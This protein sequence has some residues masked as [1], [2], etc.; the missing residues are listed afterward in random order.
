MKRWIGLGSLAIVAYLV[1]LVA[2]FPAADAYQW[3]VPHNRVQAY[4]LSG[5]L[6]HGHADALI[7]G[8]QRLDDVRWDFRPDALLSAKLGFSARATLPDGH[9]STR[10]RISP[11]GRITLRDLKV[12]TAL[13]PVVRGL[14]SRPLPI[15]FN[16]RI[17]AVFRHVI[18]EDRHVE[19]ADGM[20][21]LD[22]VEIQTGQGLPL[23]SFGIRLTDGKNGIDGR[24]M[25]RKGPLKVDGTLAMKK[26]GAVDVRMNVKTKPSAGDD[27]KQALNLVGLR[28]PARGGLIHVTGNLNQ[29][30]SFRS[31]LRQL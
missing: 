14:G 27:L 4:G 13:G 20:I 12:G 10:A 3:F 6:W 31:T 25:D 21:T 15:G 23:G 29:P 30:G 26:N 8:R 2:G 11:G 5:T 7:S 28:Q 24:I 1:F 18:L 9:L 17:E 19:G 16:G 22:D